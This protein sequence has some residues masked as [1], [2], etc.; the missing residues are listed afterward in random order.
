MCIMMFLS[1]KHA[2]FGHWIAHMSIFPDVVDTELLLLLF[3]IDGHI[4]HPLLLCRHLFFTYLSRIIWC[5]EV[6]LRV[7]V[8]NVKTTLNWIIC[9]LNFHGF[10]SWQLHH[11][12]LV[13]AQKVT[14]HLCLHHTVESAS[15]TFDVNSCCIPGNVFILIIGVRRSW[16]G[17][18]ETIRLLLNSYVFF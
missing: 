7:W 1:E 10:S 4:S 6:N 2:V 11:I 8:E 14:P 3:S 17:S 5:R 13:T 15:K 18:F 12:M 9:R 16:L